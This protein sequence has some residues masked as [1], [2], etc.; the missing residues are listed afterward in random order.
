MC[1]NTEVFASNQYDCSVTTISRSD[2]GFRSAIVRTSWL[3]QSAVSSNVFVD[4]S[5]WTTSFPTDGI[6]RPKAREKGQVKSSTLSRI[7]EFFISKFHP[8][9]RIKRVELLIEPG[10]SLGLMIRGG[11][12]YGLGIFITGVDKDSVAD[13]AG[14]MVCLEFKNKMFCRYNASNFR[15][16]IKY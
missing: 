9:I 10:Q 3:I 5:S 1:A 13:R 4:G 7:F 14:L 8:P 11:V 12:E 6:W 2:S 15:L 16:E